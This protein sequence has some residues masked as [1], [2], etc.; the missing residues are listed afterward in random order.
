MWYGVH[1]GIG[2]TILPTGIHGVRFIGIIITDT[3]LTGMII[4]MVITTI[5]TFTVIRIIVIITIVAVA[6]TLIRYTSIAKVGCTGILT[7]G[8]T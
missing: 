1:P 6:H 4:I 2:A 7:R 8:Q 5:P 3:I